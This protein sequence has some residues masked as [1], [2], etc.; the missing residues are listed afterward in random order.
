LKIGSVLTWFLPIYPWKII[1]DDKEEDLEKFT[2]TIIKLFL[3]TKSKGK[4]QFC[5]HKINLKLI[6]TT[7]KTCN[8]Q[9]L[10]SND[11][12][13]TTIGFLNIIHATKIIK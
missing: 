6:S 11:G 12:S 3:K 4:N 7:I 13:D 8:Q 5:S 1:P 9:L 2:G 10:L